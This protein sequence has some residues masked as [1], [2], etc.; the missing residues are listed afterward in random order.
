[1]RALIFDVD[2]TLVDSLPLIIEAVQYAMEPELGRVVSEAEV[3]SRFGPTETVMFERWLPEAAPRIE[4]RFYRYYSEHHHR[5]HL[6]PG[7]RELI[8]RA[9][10]LGLPL[11]VVTGKGDLSTGITLRELGIGDLFDVIVTGDQVEAPK[12]D[13]QGVTLALRKLGADPAQSLYLGDTPADVRAARGAGAQSGGVLWARTVD[14]AAL[15]AVK[16]DYL[17]ARPGEVEEWLEA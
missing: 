14:R 9:G 11:G 6:F 15:E 7:I 17:F 12:P 3:V 2:G 1:M 13:P 8:R 4:E 16:P 5:I 10:E